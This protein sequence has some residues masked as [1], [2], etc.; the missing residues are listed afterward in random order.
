M[1]HDDVALLGILQKLDKI[2]KFNFFGGWVVVGVV[3]VG[4]SASLDD[5]LVVGPGGV[6]QED[7]G[8][9]D[10]LL[11]QFEPQSQGTSA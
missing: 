2:V 1:Q 7:V 11:D 10:L 5:V 3:L 9:R 8:G 6:G 4:Q